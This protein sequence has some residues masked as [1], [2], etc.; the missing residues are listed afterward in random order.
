MEKKEIYKQLKTVYEK[1]E[2]YKKDQHD[3]ISMLENLSCILD[4]ISNSTYPNEVE[5]QKA[6]AEKN[7]RLLEEYLAFYKKLYVD[8][9]LIEMGRRRYDFEFN[10]LIYLR[11]ISSENYYY[12][13]KNCSSWT[14]DA[15]PQED[16][17]NFFNYFI[18]YFEQ[19]K[20]SVAQIQFDD[21]SFQAACEV[22]DTQVEVNV[23]LF[24]CDF[25]I[26]IKFFNERLINIECLLYEHT[27]RLMQ[28]YG[29][30]LEYSRKEVDLY[31]HFF[32]Q[33]IYVFK[34]VGSMSDSCRVTLIRGVLGESLTTLFGEGWFDIVDRT[35]TINAKIS[36]S[37]HAIDTSIILGKQH[38]FKELV[39]GYIYNVNNIL[40][41]IFCDNWLNTNS[42]SEYNGEVSWIELKETSNVSIK[43]GIFNNHLAVECAKKPKDIS[44][45]KTK[46][47]KF[48]ELDIPEKYITK[49]KNL[50]K[51]IKD[52]I[53]MM[54][55]FYL[56]NF[57]SND[58]DLFLDIEYFMRII[59]FNKN[60]VFTI[61]SNSLVEQDKIFKKAQKLLSEEAKIYLGI[62]KKL[63]K[64][65]ESTLVKWKEN[66]FISHRVKKV[67]YLHSQRGLEKFF[68]IDKRG[69]VEFNH[70][71]NILK[72]TDKNS[73]NDIFILN[74]ND[75]IKISKNKE[76]VKNYLDKYLQSSF[77]ALRLK[78]YFALRPHGSLEK[79]LKLFKD[80]L[81][82]LK[83]TKKN[84]G[85][86]LLAHLGVHALD[87]YDTFFIDV[88]LIFQSDFPLDMPEQDI[89][90]YIENVRTKTMDSWKNY[91]QNKKD[92]VEHQKVK[93]KQTAN[94]VFD[95]NS[96]KGLVFDVADEKI[97]N[98]S[99]ENQSF[100][101][102]KDYQKDQIKRFKDDIS[103]LY[104]G[105]QL[106]YSWNEILV[107]KRIVSKTKSIRQLIRGNLV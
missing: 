80:Y 103:N 38:S 28:E 88:T 37:I 1:S 22:F 99:M 91:V 67:L 47:K 101:E 69:I 18:K 94:H 52:E 62:A 63:L 78:F 106:L 102:I 73:R 25:L 46:I 100:I 35:E 70:R 6:K 90:T 104:M 54:R 12:L 92:N 23:P 81:K 53:Q 21:R 32:I 77:F 75:S 26:N 31:N 50:P 95:E 5:Y 61:A 105:Y 66:S 68:E 89:K 72:E 48:I 58:T 34:K 41:P 33:K 45:V 59:Q 29:L 85:A 74:H 14:I 44:T 60:N 93:L 40:K 55:V 51:E 71:L 87:S 42:L 98:S 86:N 15:F 4:E 79:N 36:D 10:I 56:N 84:S 39:L 30:V 11:Y 83:R 13:I 27:S 17:F 49:I 8:L 57:D 24:F 97:C 76:Q 82:N 107:H 43:E 9:D 19:K 96:Y 16:F 20:Q 7:F 64:V 65:D 3:L 2:C